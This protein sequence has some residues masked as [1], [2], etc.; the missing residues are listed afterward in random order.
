MEVHRLHQ[1]EANLG[2]KFWRSCV[3]VWVNSLQKHPANKATASG[4]NAYPPPA[5]PSWAL[6]KTI[7]V[8]CV[9]KHF[10]SHFF[11]SWWNWHFSLFNCMLIYVYGSLCAFVYGHMCK[12]REV[13]SRSEESRPNK[14]KVLSTGVL[15]HEFRQ[16]LLDLRAWHV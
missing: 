14:Q 11:L 16:H 9:T 6:Q 4:V 13:L 3:C 12:Y 15:V 8:Y 2:Y 1:F 10:F 5:Q 7:T